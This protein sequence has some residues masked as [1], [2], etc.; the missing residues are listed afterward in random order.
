MKIKLLLFF[1][2]ISINFIFSQENKVNNIFTKSFDLMQEDNYF[3]AL[4]LLDSSLLKVSN[5]NDEARILNQI[6]LSYVQLQSYTTAEKLFLK[7]M[8]IYDSLNIKTELVGVYANLVHSYMLS[9]NFVKY[10]E[11]VSIL[12][13]RLG[14]GDGYDIFFLFETELIALSK[15]NKFKEVL[16]KSIL[17]HKVL[18]EQE[19]IGKYKYLK[20]R[21]KIIYNIYQAFAL[22]ELGIDNNKANELLTVLKNLDFTKELWFNERVF[23][24]K[25]DVFLYKF[26]Y[27]NFINKNRDSSKYYYNQF[28]NA[29]NNT[30]HYLEQKRMKNTLFLEEFLEK[31]KVYA[32]TIT[33]IKIKKEKEKN[34]KYIGIISFGIFLLLGLFAYSFV[35]YNN[36][37]KLNKSNRNIKKLNEKLENKNLKLKDEVSKNK[38]LIELNDR[39][40]FTKIAQ[41]SMTRDKVRK[42]NIEITNLI[43]DKVLRTEPQLNKIKKSLDVIIT[44]NEI[45][46]D[47]KIQFEKTRPDFFIKLKQISPKLTVNELKHCSYIITKLRSKDVANLINISPRS[48]ETIRYRIKKKLDLA[49]ESSLFDFLHKI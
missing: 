23:I 36:S 2:I 26:K 6:G 21:L 30:I 24:Y 40:I 29:N 17:A 42:V 45:W 4:K 35:I 38:E 3:L 25:A 27:F 49:K 14:E 19:F 9:E 16:E 22:M 5:K 48:V 8:H 41:I 10:N 33:Q 47:F 28:K 1:C 12:K 43:N 20:K 13:K 18:D 34:I 11:H 44:K 37:K 31:K 39:N 15:Q 46:E 7:S 32:E